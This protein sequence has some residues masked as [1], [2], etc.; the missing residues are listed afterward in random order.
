MK[1]YQN[2]LLTPIICLLPERDIIVSI[3]RAKIITREYAP[4]I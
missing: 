3:G 4:L 1:Y 2:L